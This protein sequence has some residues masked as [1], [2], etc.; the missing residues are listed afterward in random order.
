MLNFSYNLVKEVKEVHTP[1]E[2]NY[3]LKQGWILLLVA[4][5]YCLGRLEIK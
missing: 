1:E 5:V 3:L 2:C 4:D